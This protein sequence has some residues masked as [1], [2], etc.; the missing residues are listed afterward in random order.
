VKRSER[1]ALPS[2]DSRTEATAR[3]ATLF[4]GTYL[5][6]IAI[7][8][9]TGF[10]FAIYFLVP[11]FFVESLHAGPFEVGVVSAGFGLAG[12]CALPF[13]G[14]LLDGGGER[15]ALMAGAALLTLS[16]LAF[17]TVREPGLFP[18]FLRLV[19]GV[20]VSLV[21]NGGS[22]I[23]SRRAPEGRL[24]EAIGIFAAANL[25]T[26]AV[27]PALAETLAERH[28]YRC[29]FA[30]AAAGGALGLWLALGTPASEP[31]TRAPA[32]DLAEH[33]SNPLYTRLCTVLVCVGL[34]YGMILTFS[35]PF[36]LALGETSVRSFF[37]AFAATAVLMRVGFSRA[38]DRLGHA[39][40]ASAFLVVYGVAVGA[41]ALLPWLPLA[42][43]GALFGV[44][45]GAFMPAYTALM[46]RRTPEPERGRMFTLFN[47]AF[48]LGHGLVMPLGALVE[49]LGY[50]SLFV[51]VALPI[52]A[53]P[54]L[55]HEPRP[56][57]SA[58]RAPR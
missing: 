5:R 1:A 56:Q 52:F 30:L 55:V 3:E 51:G 58:A 27:A 14:P 54:L 18:A 45:H 8:L 15:R 17:C 37:S 11:K 39:R 48:G 41:F 26:Q 33:L 47:A 42:A 4:D 57:C 44:A 13:V 2:A 25:I 16:S 50:P 38:I 7:Q 35:T 22:M 34:G 28:G 53:L 20:A 46:V 21:V 24:A 31:R 29:T 32:R 49:R 6:L 12:L 9:A 19:Q 36:A 43:L 23:V 10:G 40:A